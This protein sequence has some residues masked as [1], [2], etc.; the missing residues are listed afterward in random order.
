MNLLVLHLSSFQVG[1]RGDGDQ[2]SWYKNWNRSAFQV[3]ICIA[4]TPITTSSHVCK[5]TS[6]P[7]RNSAS[8]MNITM[9]TFTAVRANFWCRGGQKLSYGVWSI[10]AEVL[11]GPYS[12]PKPGSGRPAWPVGK[13]PLFGN[14]WQSFARFRLYRHR[15]LQVNTCFAA[16]FKIYKII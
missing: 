5:S 13:L 6:P 4:S 16:F 12:A 8:K 15:S 11:E 1:R 7:F 3:H 10:V 2:G 9:R 14:F